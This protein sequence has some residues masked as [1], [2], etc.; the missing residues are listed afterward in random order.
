MPFAL[1]ELARRSPLK[2][3]CRSPPPLILIF[4]SLWAL[5]SWHHIMV[6]ETAQQGCDLFM[7]LLI[8]MRIKGF[9]VTGMQMVSSGDE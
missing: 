2:A 6:V 4:V 3:C 5:I 9:V 7:P 8:P 1:V